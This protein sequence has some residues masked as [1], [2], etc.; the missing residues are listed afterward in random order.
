MQPIHVSVTKRAAILFAALL[1]ATSAPKVRAASPSAQPSIVEV[2]ATARQEPAVW[3]YTIDKPPDDWRQPQFDDSDWAEG[4]AGFG[5]P[6]TPSVAVHSPWSTADIWL[7]RQI[8]LPPKGVRV[9]SL[10]LL[11]FHDEDVEIYLNGILAARQRG[12]V[13][14]YEPIE[15][16]P[17][18]R[19]LIKPGA[20]LLIA[21]HCHQRDGGQGIDVGLAS[22]S[23]ELM[24]EVRKRPYRS[25]ALSNPGRAD[26]GHQLFLDEQRLGCTRCHTTDGSA[27]RAGPDLNAVGDKFTRSD[28]IN[29]VL[30]PS[31]EIA[32]GYEATVITTRSDDAFI[33]VIKEATDE[34]LG[35]ME[36]DGK[37]RRVAAAEVRERR[38]TSTSM[39]PTGLE[40]GLTSDEFADLIA[41]LT[42]LRLPGL[43]DAGRQGMPT[44]IPELNPPVMLLPVHDDAHRFDH[45][46]WMGQLPREPGVFL[47]CEHETGRIWRLSTSAAGAAREAG[48]T[49]SLWGD[50]R[51]EVRRGGATGL[52]GLAFHPHF[53]E[54]RKYYIQHQLQVG[55]RLVAR[56][57]EKRAAPDFER[58]SGQ[59]SRTIIEFPCS[60][61]V[62]TG[63]GIEFG[64]DGFL[65]IGMGDTGPQGDPQGHGQDLRTLL[66]K[67]LRIDVD[68]EDA[69]LA[70][71]IPPD[72]PLRGRAGARPEIWA[73]GFRE[74]WR[75]TFD[76]LNR[77]LWVGD[78]GQDRIEEVTI[79]RPGENHGWNV[80]EGFDLFSTRYRA[81]SA[82][83]I[84]PVFAYNRRLGNSIT[85]G[86][87]IRDGSPFEGVYICGDFTSRRVWGLR[88]SDRKLTAIWQLCRSPQS[89]ASFA[90]DEA[91]AIYL[92]GYEGTI[93]RMNFTGAAPPSK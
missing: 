40:T 72:N 12:F 36:G 46:A 28:L 7:R 22:V 23:T 55:G 70:Y 24:D 35:L 11:A 75:F 48:A 3:R 21:V 18:A 51:D 17:E 84:P 6:G 19:A 69:G 57:S 15:I 81:E 89:I 13:R 54:N 10:Q 71:A 58:D 38:T 33:G 44:D 32:V 61:D 29:A 25:A 91:G 1:A 62:H 37:L 60:T 49:K 59:P 27:G 56:V 86:Y 64:P 41:Y 5:S 39:M 47:V 26:A 20:S 85:G 77:D 88:Q 30:N 14:D 4:R 74:P 16:L 68:H 2:I 82:A 52:L 83:L 50:F 92:V 79:V 8:V 93:F 45:P 34:H 90:R 53:R 65:Y 66:G 78:V 73:S 31:S 87:V 63:G 80:Y 9:A 42:S 43:A 67:M 76:P